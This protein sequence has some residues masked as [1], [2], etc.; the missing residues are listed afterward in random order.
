MIRFTG[1]VSIIILRIVRSLTSAAVM[2]RNESIQLPPGG[3]IC[4]YWIYGDKIKNPQQSLPE[5]VPLDQR[6]F[7]SLK[8]AVR[9]FLNGSAILTGRK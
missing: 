5:F 2:D 9:M 4:D 8:E 6:M 3:D 1:M 7:M